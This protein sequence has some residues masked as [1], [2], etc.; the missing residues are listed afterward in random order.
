MLK[1]CPECGSSNV[2]TKVGW[3]ENMYFK[4][5]VVCLDCGMR[6]PQY[7]FPYYSEPTVYRTIDHWNAE[8][9]REPEES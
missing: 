7:T 6:G 2:A 3:A 1:P 5:E 9:H 8:A 4:A